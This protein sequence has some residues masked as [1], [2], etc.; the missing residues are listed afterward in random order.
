M[1]EFTQSITM[2]EQNYIQAQQLKEKIER[3]SAEVEDMRKHYSIMVEAQQ[4]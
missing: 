3:M 2:L 1:S 4:L